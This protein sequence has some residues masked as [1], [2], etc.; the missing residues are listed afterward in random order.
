MINAVINGGD[1]A[2]ASAIR[3]ISDPRLAGDRR[4]TMAS[5]GGRTYL[6]FGQDFQGGYSL[7]APARPASPRSTAT[8]S[9]ASGSIDNGKTVGHRGL[10]G[11][12]AIRPTSA[13]ATAT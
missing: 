3:Q 5:I 12:S 4:Q 8:R 2:K 7:T 13:G 10:R 11:A 6:V 9:R 1:V